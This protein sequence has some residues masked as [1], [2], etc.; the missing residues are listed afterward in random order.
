MPTININRKVFE[1]LVGKKLPLEKLKDRISYLGTDLEE[2]TKDEIIVEVFPNRPDM[3]SE[4]GFAR[5]FSSFIGIKTG[6]RTYKVNKSNHKMIIDSSVKTVRP[7]TACCI[8]KNL[9]FNEEKIREI[10]Q[11]QEKLHLTYGRKRKKVAIGIYPSEKIKYP[12]TFKALPPEKIKFQPLEYPIELTGKQILEKHPK[13]KEYAHL[14][15]GK[16]KYPLFVDANNQVLSMPPIINSENVGK[17][18]EKTKDVFI[19]VS[20]FDFKAC[21]ICLNIL[22]TTLA[23]MGGKIYSMEINFGNKKETTPNLNPSKMKLNL[24]YINKRLGLNLKEKE[25]KKLLERMGYKYLNKTVLIPAYRADIL[26]QVDLAEDIAIAY[27]Y[28]NFNEEI[29]NISTIG[30]EDPF[31]IFK[32]KISNLLVGL[33]LLEVSTYHILSEENHNQKMNYDADVI[34]LD[35][36]ASTEY[37]VLRSWIVPSLMKILSENTH[38]EYPQNIFEISEV[39]IHNK[40]TETNVEEATRLAVVLCDKDANFTRIK[41]VFDALMRSL[42]LSYKIEETKHPSFI[43]GRVARINIKGKKVAYIGEVHPEVISNFD[44]KMPVACFELNLSDLFKFI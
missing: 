7:F 14:L 3:L 5:A 22:A 19:E 35:N 8:I 11:I 37:S 33:N 34:T 31:E 32:R 15:E 43:P 1:K 42:K 16:T 6:L 38:N 17:I 28:E 23:D 25:A 9:N 27:G 29:P 36:P 40:K 26:H 2:I 13:G 20:G 30:Q 44:I 4:Q 18:T 39:F 21:K 12:I 24:D 10:I 41:Q